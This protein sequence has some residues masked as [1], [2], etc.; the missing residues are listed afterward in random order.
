M[1]VTGVNTSIDIDIDDLLLE[2]GEDDKKSLLGELLG[3]V[4]IDE[5]DVADAIRES[6]LNKD[7]VIEALGGSVEDDMPEIATCVEVYGVDYDAC[8]DKMDFISRVLEKMPPYELKQALC[9][10]L[11]VGSYQ[12]DAKLR[13]KLEDIIT[14]K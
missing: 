5:A 7:D 12:D 2:M 3:E 9:N 10:A 11:W 6:D 8:N 4:E 13:E 14:A 1:I